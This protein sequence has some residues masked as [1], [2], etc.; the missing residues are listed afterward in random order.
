MADPALSG[1][2]GAVRGLIGD[3]ASPPH[4][5]DDEIAADLAL[6]R[7]ALRDFSLWPANADLAPNY[8]NWEYPGGGL[9]LDYSLKDVN[10]SPLTPSYADPLSGKFDFSTAQTVV[11][12]SGAAYDV[13]DAAV[14]LLDKLLAELAADFDFTSDGASY[15]RSQKFAQY[16]ELRKKLQAKTGPKIANLLRNDYI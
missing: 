11:K 13:Y 14:R 7:T 8:Y 6:S 12:L 9:S 16:Q 15:Q 2:I 3:R 5:S 1:L 4:F 10:G